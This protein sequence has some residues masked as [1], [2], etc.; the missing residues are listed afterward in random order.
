VTGEPEV[1]VAN[2]RRSTPVVV[3]EKDARP[4]LMAGWESR[5]LASIFSIR[6]ERCRYTNSSHRRESVP[7]WGL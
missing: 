6:W 4:D 5:S 1:I 2:T 3:Y 7:A